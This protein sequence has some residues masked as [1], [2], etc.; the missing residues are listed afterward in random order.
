[1]FS[2]HQYIENANN[3][4]GQYNDIP[5]DSVSNRRLAFIQA[6][7]NDRPR[8]KQNFSSSES[9]FLNIFSNFALAP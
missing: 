7:I 4:I 5:L 3:L 1:M 2:G 6:K 8:E 9:E